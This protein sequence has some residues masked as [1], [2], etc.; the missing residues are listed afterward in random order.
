M[1]AD[2]TRFAAMIA[3]EVALRQ[4]GYRIISGVDE[5]GRGPLAGPVVAAA[6]LLLCP[7]DEAGAAHPWLCEV[8]DSKQVSEEQRESLCAHILRDDS[9]FHVGTGLAEVEEIDRTN[10]LRATQAAMRRAL[11]ALIFPPEFVLVDGNRTIPAL[12]TPQECV[13]KGDARC[14]SIAAAS[15]VAKVTRDGLMR[16]YAHTYPHYGFEQ[17]KGY[18][19][20]QHVRALRDHGTCP[21][22][23][24]VFAASALAHE[25]DDD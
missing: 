5:A 11:D 12:A 7:P 9:P 15:I 17:H 13:V 4:E 6:A 22:H 23:R 25:R 20:A 18:G 1:A 3:R 24:R 14:L 10:I 2:A 16:R 19:T 21:L 8:Y